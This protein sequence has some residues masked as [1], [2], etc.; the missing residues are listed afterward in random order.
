[1]QKLARATLARSRNPAQRSVVEL[2]ALDLASSARHVV[3]V[4]DAVRESSLTPSPCELPEAQRRALDF[5]RRRLAAGDQLL[6]HEGFPELA[7]WAP[8][9]AVAAPAVPASAGAV[10]APT[11]ALV[12]RFQPARWKLEAPARRAR[13]AWRV[14]EVSDASSH[15]GAA[16][17]ALRS[18][19]PRL[20]E[21]L[22]SGDDL[23]DLCL[24]VAIGRLGDAGAA[25]AMQQLSQRG[26]SPATC[27]AARQAWLML[28]APAERA[29][30]VA[31]L[32]PVWGD[33][34]DS[35]LPA[36]ALLDRIEAVLPRRDATW[37]SLL[38]DWYDIAWVRAEPRAAL[39][40][41]L[42]V[43]PLQAPHFQGVRYVYKAAEMRRDAEVLGLLHARFENSVATLGPTGA[44]QYKSPATGSWIQRAVGG[45]RTPAQ[46]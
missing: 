36:D 45:A 13:A 37:A 24:A 33:E 14:A 15:D 34:L 8:E 19:V 28:L 1:M 3:T 46:A 30:Q 35:D 31:T 18:L 23:L 12:A 10:P 41:L 2:V 32:L 17:Q 20:V 5:I 16:Q 6:S 29:A 22:G 11:A 4:R 44:R 27:R 7:S 43:L 25:E 40:R 21:L 9:V 42:Q 26:R 38:T 39:L